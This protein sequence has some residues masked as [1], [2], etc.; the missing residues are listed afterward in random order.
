[1]DFPQTRDHL[2]ELSRFIDEMAAD[3]ASG[4][5]TTIQ[6]FAE[7][8]FA[9]YVP[10][11]R[12]AIEQVVTGWIEMAT[13]RDGKTLIHVTTVL[14][15]LRSLPEYLEADPA[16]RDL[17]TWMVLFHDV[18]KVPVPGSHDFVH[19]FRSA[20]VAGPAL[21]AVGF[22]VNGDKAAVDAWS[23]MTH[24][25]VVYDKQFDAPI[26]DNTQL[27]EIIA[28]LETLFGRDTPASA[29]IKGV[30]FH[31]SISIDP[32]YPTPAPVTDEQFVRYIGPLAFQLCKAMMLVDNDGWTLFDPDTGQQRRQQTLAGFARLAQLY[33]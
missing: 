2:P 27:P 33:A 18:A 14:V 24:K 6:D 8:A 13:H 30:L 29:I 12:E 25:A 28:T 20:A 16:T 10:E 22:S 19:G 15:A 9:F 5:L 3:R 7:R 17:M 31:L 32:N 21:A 23:V 26:Q 1:M 4:K 11:Q